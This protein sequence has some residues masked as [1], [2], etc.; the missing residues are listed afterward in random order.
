[1]TT[2]TGRTVVVTGAA[3][4]IGAAVAAAV[5]QA[6]GEVI[7]LDRNEGPGIR[8]HDVRDPLAWSKLA[9]DLADVPVHGL[10]NCAGVTWRA[11]L[12]DVTAQALADTHAVNVGGPLQA[13]Q[14]LVPSMPAGGSI[15]TIGSLAALQGH[16]PLAYT[17][18]KWA[19]RGLTRTAAMELGERGIRVNTVHPGFIETSMTASAPAEFR[20]ASIAAAPLGRAGTP[21]EVASVVVFLL[22]DAASYLT[23]ADIP[24][25]GGASAHA[26]AKPVS[27]ALRPLYQPPA[28]DN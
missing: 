5:R 15:V 22:G 28:Q 13:I 27:D 11:R 10:V 8:R 20:A 4:G 2:L 9:A 26:G 14:T 25:D 3:S 6:G 19:L 18:S 16:Y 7:G 24:V 23:G 1:M 12:G 17:T 21:A